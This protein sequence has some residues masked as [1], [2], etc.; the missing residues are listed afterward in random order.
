MRKRSILSAPKWLTNQDH[1][2]RRLV[3]SF[4]VRSAL[5]ILLSNS[6]K[7][8]CYTMR[9]NIRQSLANV[10]KSQWSQLCSRRERRGYP[11][12]DNQRCSPCTHHRVAGL[13]WRFKKRKWALWF[14]FGIGGGKS[15]DIFF[16]DNFSPHLR[17]SCTHIVAPHK[18]WCEQCSS[19]TKN[20]LFREVIRRIRC[21]G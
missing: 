12:N 19:L 15:L 1:N 8:S 11:P 2:S 7:E 21:Q 9:E 5:K 10:T 17:T 18:R 6:L 14:M 13:S 20:K 3:V 16:T 4:N